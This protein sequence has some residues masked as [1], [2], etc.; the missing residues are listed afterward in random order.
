MSNTAKCTTLSLIFSYSSFTGTTKSK[1]SQSSAADII[2]HSIL[3]NNGRAWLNKSIYTY[4]TMFFPYF[5][6][7]VK[8]TQ[9]KE[10][11]REEGPI[12]ALL[13]IY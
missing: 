6:V 8:R 10:E 13:N 9:G 5:H 2:S 12:A 1:K 7:I 4:L 3:E 11:V